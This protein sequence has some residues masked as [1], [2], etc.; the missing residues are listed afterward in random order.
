MKFLKGG[1][2]FLLVTV[3]I[4][5]LTSFTIDATDSFS[6][7]QT[8]L[9]LLAGSALESE[10][11]NGAVRIDLAGK[12]ICVDRYENSADEN[13]PI[14]SPAFG[15]ESKENID[16]DGCVS[17]SSPDVQPWTFISFHQ[18]KALCAKKDMRLPSPLE[19]YEAG[20]GTPDSEKCNVETQSVSKAGAYP[21]C[22]SSRGVY[23]MVGNTWE[24]IDAQ[25]TYG[26]YEGR[27]LP[28]S[29]YV[30]EV[31]TAGVVIESSGAPEPIYGEDYFHS[32]LQGVRAMMRGGH[33]SGGKDA[34]L[35]SVHTKV[36]PSFSSK[37]TGFRCVKTL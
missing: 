36:E 23:D 2:R 7:S 5:I 11:P 15:L 1:I 28:E 17:V 10:C 32:D 8:A 22:V 27:Q 33:Y 18:A 35:F 24:W 13:C 26:E 29:G 9:S 16:A 21:E 37:G 4:V 34:G 3:G 19:W 20:L 30:Q 14:L 31:D 25:I 6:R 12:S